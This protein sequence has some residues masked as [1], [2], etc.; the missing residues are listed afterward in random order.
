MLWRMSTVKVWQGKH[1]PLGATVTPQGVNFAL[2]S[3]YA[4]GVDLCLFDHIASPT[5]TVRIRMVERTEHVWH[6]LLP[7]V[8]PG[9]LYGYR[10]YGAYD[11]ANG[12]RFNDSKLLLDPYAK[13]ITGL[14]NWSDEMF[15]YRLAPGNPDADMERDYRDD[16]WGMPKC[17]VVDDAFDWEG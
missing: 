10:V 1:Y 7:D 5:E 12:H 13:A 16:A 17:V 14:I 8:T 9:Q 2:F 15:A 6:C 4:T 11:P 3:Q